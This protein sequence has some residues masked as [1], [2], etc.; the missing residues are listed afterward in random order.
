MTLLDAVDPSL[1]SDFEEEEIKRL[2]I[3][4]LWCV[5]PDSELRPSM[6]EAIKVL[7]SEASVPLLPS[8]KPVASYWAPPVRKQ[9]IFSTEKGSEKLQLNLL[10]YK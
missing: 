1:G 4:G 9:E 2:M 6:R 3:L 5:H 7:N 10:M 8:K